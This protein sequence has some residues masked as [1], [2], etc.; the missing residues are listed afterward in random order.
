MDERDGPGLRLA[1][2]GPVSEPP[3][4]YTA[5]M[6]PLDRTDRRPGP[7]SGALELFP[8]RS[9]EERGVQ[10]AALAAFVA[11][12][13]LR[14]AVVTVRTPNVL[15]VGTPFDQYALRIATGLG[16]GPSSLVP[17]LY[18]HLLASL[19]RLYG[20]N[21]LPILLS[22]ALLGA[23]LVLPVFLLARAAGLGLW[24]SAVA[25]AICAVFPQAVIEARH[26]TPQAMSGLLF[27]LGAYLWLR[28]KPGPSTSDCL[29]S[30]FFVGL[31]ILGRTGLFLPALVLIGARSYG[32]TGQGWLQRRHKQGLVLAVIIVTLAPWAARNS[33]LHRRP[34]FTENT[35]ALRLRAANVPGSPAFFPLLPPARVRTPDNLVL[36][37]NALAAE[38]TA[39]YLLE[40]P[41]R[42]AHV[43]GRRGLDFFSFEFRGMRAGR[44]PEGWLGYGL[45]QAVIYGSVLTLCLSWLLLT[46]ARGSVER[47]LAWT[48]GGFLLLSSITG[49]P[50]EGRLFGLP[51]LGILAARGL[52]GVPRILPPERG[53]STGSMAR[54]ILFLT[55][56]LVLWVHGW[57]SSP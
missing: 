47:T 5:R 57:G 29:G 35:W 50:S 40:H 6:Y 31:S 25:S 41:R 26:L 17:P 4:C 54:R 7:P 12:L 27:V 2:T 55:L 44:F 39:R 20:Y 34:V 30:G 32:H 38:E 22:Q 42:V 46:G 10:A 21:A 53:G 48:V 15:G 52:E 9:H 33:L 49:S 16:F 56:C 14:A 45:L 19:Y 24:G 1:G 18:P 51:F 13:V 23:L 37:D 8:P 36:T 3:D 11:A 28:G 43:W